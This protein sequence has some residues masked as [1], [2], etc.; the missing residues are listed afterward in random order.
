MQMSRSMDWVH[1]HNVKFL[2]CKL[3]RFGNDIDRDRYLS[4]IMKKPCKT[5]FVKHFIIQAKLYPYRN[6]HYS[7]AQ[8]VMIGIIVVHLYIGDI[9]EYILV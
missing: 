1:F 5:Y 4:Y 6:R 2:S 7:N 3:T 9:Y 8:T